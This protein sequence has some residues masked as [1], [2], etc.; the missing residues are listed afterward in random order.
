M[1]TMH[2]RTLPQ[3]TWTLLIALLAMLF[4]Q[5]AHAFPPLSER[6]TV[7][8]LL[9]VSALQPGQKATAAVV[10]DIKPGL[11][12]QSRTPLDE[13]LIRLDVA[14]EDTAAITFGRPIYPPG[15]IEN[16]PALGKLSVY[17]GR[18]TVLVPITVKPDA[19]LGPVKLTGAL[20]MQICDDKSCFMPDHPKLTIDTTIVSPS[21]AV[22]A[23][24]PDVFATREATS[25]VTLRE[26]IV[27]FGTALLVGVIFNVMPC[28]L[29][30]VPLKI[31]GFYEVAKHSRAKSIA[32]GAVFSVGLISSFGVLAIFI[33]ALRWLDWGELFTKPWFVAA[34]VTIL[35]AMAIS[36]FGVFTVRLPGALYNVT[37]RHDTYVGNFLFGILT[38]ALST[39]CTFGLF[40]GLLT[41]ALAQTPAIGVALIMTVGVGMA[42]PYFILSALPE[43]AR[44]FPRTGPWA[45]LVK[46][47]MAFLLLGTAVYF[48]R[49]FIQRFFDDRTMWW[50]I[51]AVIAAA[52]VFLI[53]K[54]I[55]YSPRFVPRAIA[56][57]IAVLMI[58]P[59]LFAARMLTVRPYDWKPY[60]DEV[61]A[62]T[63]MADQIAVIDFTATWCGNC[64]YVEAFVLHRASVIDAVKSSNVQMIKADVTHA[65]ALAKPLL[66]Q[67]SP[68]G[69]IPL[70]AVYGPG[71]EEPIKLVGIYSPQDIIDAIAKA[72]GK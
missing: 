29:P 28:V 13:N 7:T 60:S 65:D 69:A 36:T 41:W 54:S 19:P 1:V 58:A 72:R 62:Q 17:S 20:E 52:G 32:L 38:A 59:S 33:V 50:L 42:L 55:Q 8:T 51:F 67:L 47:L 18:V 40:V 70:T 2:T 63:Q 3:P 5:R 14:F 27:Q 61:L 11:H 12:A 25:V 49:P 68:A 10:I 22:S 21:E 23:T 35:L 39:P 4:V 71:V 66:A 34:I 46:Q 64:Q 53:V 31:L 57:T 15:K 45:E 30:V 37:P 43:L 48:A 44:R 24:H 26:I 16:Y 9:D 6:A 56:F